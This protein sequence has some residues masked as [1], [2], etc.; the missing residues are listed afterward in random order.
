MAVDKER[1][2]I[3]EEKAEQIRK[4]ITVTTNHIGYSHMGGGMSMVEMAVALYYDW[5]NWSP[6]Q[7]EDPHRDRF[8]LS[9]GHCAHVLYNIFV[10]KGMY[11][12]EDLW[13]EYNQIGGRFG[14]HGNYHYVNGLE[15]STGSLGH[16]A[17]IAVGMAI[18]GRLNKDD[19]WV[20]CMTG[21]GEMDEGSN[22]EAL[23][24]AAHYGL[25]NFILICDKNKYQIGGSTTDVMSLEPFDK[26]LEAFGFD[27][28]TIEDGNDMLQVLEALD[29]LPKPDSQNRRKPIAIIS[30]TIKGIGMMEGFAD[31]EQ[32]HLSMVPN[33]FMI[34]MTFASIEALRK[35]RD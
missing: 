16:G 13:N 17:S 5:M 2:K 9:K 10:D 34:E 24:S 6:E 31:S 23:M 33:E 20:L 12:K 15:A 7:V 4:D 32:S 30:K 29:S 18:A 11:T 19:H 28:I 1:L 21:D 22:W 27:V 25:G 3:L 35:E 14:M 8:V 26:K